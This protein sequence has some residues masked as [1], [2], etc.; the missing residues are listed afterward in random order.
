MENLKLDEEKTH[1]GSKQKMKK[2]V[3]PTPV[4]CTYRLSIGQV[5]GSESK[6]GAGKRR[7]KK[8]LRL[9]KDYIE[10]LEEKP[11]SR[12]TNPALVRICN[13]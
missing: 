5:E 3:P 12:P 6:A 9:G 2:K 8:V 10:F 13:S 11:F 1:A 7:K 4:P